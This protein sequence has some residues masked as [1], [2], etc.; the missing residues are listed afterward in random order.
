MTRELKVTQYKYL[1]IDPVSFWSPH[2]GKYLFSPIHDT[3]SNTKVL[4][5]KSVDVFDHRVG[6]RPQ[7]DHFTYAFHDRNDYDADDNNSDERA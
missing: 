5:H 4:V 1:M 7:Y 6:Y 3:N 2:Q